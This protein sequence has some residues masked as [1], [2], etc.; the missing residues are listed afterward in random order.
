MKP[1]YQVALLFYQQFYFSL[2][3]D[4]E[5]IDQTF[6]AIRQMPLEVSIEQVKKWLDESHT[7]KPSKSS[8][9]FFKRL[10]FFKK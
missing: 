5:P 8:W 7:M 10:F 6:E 2:M 4:F 3:K 9:S 1:P